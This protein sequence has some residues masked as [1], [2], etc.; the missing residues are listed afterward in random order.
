MSEHGQQRKALPPAGG[1]GPEPIRV[2]VRRVNVNRNGNAYPA[3]EAPFRMPAE[4]D[5]MFA[6]SAELAALLKTMMGFRR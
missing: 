3:S 5:V 6:G 1:D 4:D 2:T